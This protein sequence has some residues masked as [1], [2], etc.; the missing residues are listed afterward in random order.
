MSIRL[1]KGISAMKNKSLIKHVKQD[2]DAKVFVFV[3]LI[4]GNKLC[5]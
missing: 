3:I 5:I 1:E 4:L 2:V